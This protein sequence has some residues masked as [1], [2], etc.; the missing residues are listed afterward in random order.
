MKMKKI[1][2]KIAVLCLS[3]IMAAPFWAGCR[4]GARDTGRNCLDVYC[5]KAGYGVEWCEEMLKAFVK[6]GWV[7]EKYPGITYTFLSNNETT[8]AATKLNGKPS[9][10]PY[11]LMFAASMDQKYLTGEYLADLTSGVYKKVIPGE[12]LTYEEKCFESY[13]ETN[14]HVEQKSDN[15][16][17][18]YYSA[19]WAG[20]MNGILYNSELLKTV[21]DELPRTTDELL[22]ILKKTLSLKNNENGKYDKGYSFIHYKGLGYWSYMFP[23]WWAQYE[24]VEGY[25]NFWNG[26]VKD[27]DQEILSKKIFEQKGRLESLKL[28]ETILDYKTGYITPEGYNKEMMTVQT[29]FLQGNGLFYVCGDWYDKE[30]ASIRKDIIAEK[31]WSYTIKQMRTPI[32]SSIVNKLTYRKD[33]DRMSDE[34]LSALVK[35]IDEGATSF[36]GVNERD[37]NYVKAAREVVHSVGAGHQAI[38]PE[39]AKEADMAKDFLLFM[40]SDKGNE[41]YIKTTQG[42]SLPFKYDV[43]EKS[44]E[45]FKKLSPFQQDR[46]TYFTDK[47]LTVNTLRYGENSPLSRFGGV[48]EFT[49]WSYWSLLASAEKNITAQGIYDK[50]ISDWT[51]SKWEVAL[52]KAGLK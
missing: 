6:E 44:P 21:T 52:S 33:G 43:K 13:N 8:F 11:D 50:T 32:I 27:G 16:E 45:T 34:T 3:L 40:A 14:K 23:I 19:P 10:N 28:F 20:G 12:S 46:L 39:Y 1:S 5:L 22:G 29:M 4:G 35:A 49:T 17:N 2:K 38:I 31:G 41:I 18:K 7:T 24:G 37:F 36:E 48:R 51:D 42:A 15:T 26:I 9:A 47:S 30:M 25:N